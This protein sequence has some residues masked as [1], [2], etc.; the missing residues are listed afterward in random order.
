MRMLGV[1]L[2]VTAGGVVAY[3]ALRGVPQTV[4]VLEQDKTAARIAA[5]GQAAAGILQAVGTLGGILGGSPGAAPAQTTAQ[6]AAAASGSSNAATI[7][8]Y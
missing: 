7:K 1:A 3:F 8:F 2:I 6:E 5:G 4:M